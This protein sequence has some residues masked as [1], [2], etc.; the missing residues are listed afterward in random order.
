MASII[1]AYAFDLDN[2]D[3]SATSG[4]EDD[5]LVEDDSEE[6]LPKAIVPLADMLNADADRNNVSCSLKLDNGGAD[7]CHR[8]IWS[9]E[10]ML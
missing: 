2:D 5:K 8:P 3:G 10:N 1:L 4:T 9:M 6:V 7:R